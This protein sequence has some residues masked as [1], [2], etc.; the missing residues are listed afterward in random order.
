MS[1]SKAADDSAKWYILITLNTSDI[2]GD[3]NGGL[4]N[5]VYICP[6]ETTSYDGVLYFKG[7][8]EVQMLIMNIALRKYTS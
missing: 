3:L 7:S 6:W 1:F 8:E 4:P 2:L 5:P